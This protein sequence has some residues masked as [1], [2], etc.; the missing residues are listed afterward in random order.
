VPLKIHHLKAR[1][2]I[3]NNKEDE[4]ETALVIKVYYIKM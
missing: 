2:F 1:E 4:W 3:K